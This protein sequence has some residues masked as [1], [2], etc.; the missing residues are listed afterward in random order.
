MSDYTPTTD[1]VEHR[2]AYDELYSMDCEA[3]HHAFRRWLAAH[4]AEVRAQA[5]REAAEVML[6]IKS[7]FHWQLPTTP[8]E[9]GTTE[10]P[11]VWLRSR[12]DLLKQGGHYQ[13]GAKCH[14]GARWVR[15]DNACAEQTKEYR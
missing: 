10:T 9:Q 14:C 2:Y 15:A 6:K 5:L 13:T 7:P 1:E 12:A 8:K 4:D 11:P 3:D